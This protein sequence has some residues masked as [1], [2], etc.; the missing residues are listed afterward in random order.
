MMHSSCDWLYQEFTKLKTFS[1][2]FTKSEEHSYSWHLWEVIAST[3]FAHSQHPP[4]QQYQQQVLE[5]SMPPA[6]CALHQFWISPSALSSPAYCCRQPPRPDKFSKWSRREYKKTSHQVCPSKAFCRPLLD[7]NDKQC[8]YSC[9]SLS[10]WY[11]SPG[12]LLFLHSVWLAFRTKPIQ[13]NEGSVTEA[14][15]T[16]PP[17]RAG[18]HYW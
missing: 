12:N 16:L 17:D 13:Q 10:Y 11:C 8:L 4:S 9:R 15:G 2:K 5:R 7:A 18:V 6:P 14:A 1:M 3:P